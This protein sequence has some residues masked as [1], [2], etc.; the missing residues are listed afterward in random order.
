[1]RV[2]DLIE[3]EFVAMV[4]DGKL[5][6]ADIE[7]YCKT[8]T[9][10]QIISIVEALELESFTIG[11]ENADVVLTDQ[12]DDEGN[13]IVGGRV[14]EPDSRFN[15]L[16]SACKLIGGLF[17]TQEGKEQ[18]RGQKGPQP[19]PKELDTD[20]AKGYF[21]KAVELGL[22]SD[23]F[24]WLKGLQMLACFAR[25]MSLKLKLGKGVNSDGTPRISWKPFES[26]F[27]VPYGKL[28]LNINDIQNKGQNP[29]KAYLIDQIFS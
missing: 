10:T 15:R 17:P 16:V 3:S 12:T 22:M 21:T 28:R 19:I 23:D 9:Q 29:K 25:E 6:N 24:R 8:K 26:L 18:Q 5:G 20:E 14:S 2:Q 11:L 13:M 27:G 7:E 4:A 1:M